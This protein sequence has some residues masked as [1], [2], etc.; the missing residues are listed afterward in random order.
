MMGNVHIFDK[1]VHNEKS[2][3]AIIHS[4]NGDLPKKGTSWPK[5]KIQIAY[6]S[7]LLDEQHELMTLL[8]SFSISNKELVE[9]L[10]IV[11]NG[12]LPKDVAKQWIE[13]NQETILEWLTGFQMSSNNTRMD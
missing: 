13:L 6:R 7:S 10:A 9:L 8:N 12:E 3:D 5:T 4:K 11:K 1:S 2:W